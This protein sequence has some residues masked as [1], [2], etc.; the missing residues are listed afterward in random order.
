MSAVRGRAA[1]RALPV[2]LFLLVSLVLRVEPLVR[3]DGGRFWWFF[4][5]DWGAAVA[6][7]ANGYRPGDLILER[8]GFV[9]LDSMVRGEASPTTVEFV[10]WPILAHL[11]PGQSYARLPLPYRDS[12]ELGAIVAREIE[13]A[14]PRR[15]WLL[16]L[17]PKDPTSV[18]FDALV[19]M[20]NHG[21]RW[22]VVQH[23]NFGVIHLVLLRPRGRAPSPG[24]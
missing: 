6:E 9:E 8:T 20:A 21:A 13:R 1:L 11:P 17:D 18:T 10:D 16:G 3:R 14:A 7:L 24:G 22:R 19:A 23:W 4:Q 15:L 2:A 12:P 5:H